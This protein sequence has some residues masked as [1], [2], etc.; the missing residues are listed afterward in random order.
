MNLFRKMEFKNDTLD[1][2]ALIRVNFTYFRLSLCDIC[3]PDN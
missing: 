2:I 3:T 1:G